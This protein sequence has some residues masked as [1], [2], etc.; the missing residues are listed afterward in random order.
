MVWKSKGETQEQERKEIIETLKLSE[1]GDKKYF[2][3]ESFGLVDLA[4]IPV[5][6]LFH[7]YE[8]CYPGLNVEKECPRLIVWIKECKTRESV[9]KSLPEPSM[10]CEFVCNMRKILGTE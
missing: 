6:S 2:G 1:P 3:G 4:L 10:V 9:A 7:A 8:T 5:S